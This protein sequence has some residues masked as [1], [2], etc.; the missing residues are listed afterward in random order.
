[1][2][3][4][5]TIFWKPRVPFTRAAHTI[6]IP[7]V[8]SGSSSSY[9]PS[10]WPWEISPAT[11]RGEEASDAVVTSDHQRFT[12]FGPRLKGSGR[13]FSANGRGLPSVTAV[14]TAK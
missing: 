2:V 1:M 12:D 4:T 6:A 9:L 8:A 11:E 3:L 13:S 7:P 5:A 14:P 10:T